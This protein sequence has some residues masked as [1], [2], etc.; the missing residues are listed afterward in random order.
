MILIVDDKPENLFSL[1]T[2]LERHSFKVDT[3]LSG[4]EALK[5]VLRQT[6]SLIILDVQ[7]PDMDGFEVAEAL[8]GSSRSKQ[9]PI[10]FLSAVNTDKKF[11]TKGFDS[12][13]V[14]YI[15]K[16]VDPDILI[17][18]VRTFYRLYEQS[19]ALNDA[20]QQLKAAHTELHLTLNSIP[21]I[22][23]T[24]TPDGQLDFVNQ[25]W[26]QYST[27]PISFPDTPEN[28]PSLEE[29]WQAALTKGN[30]YEQ[31]V[32]IRKLTNQAY[33]FHL[34]RV[35]PVKENNTL[36]KWTGV[37]VDIHDQHEINELLE[38]KIKERT[39]EL[40]E[41]NKS[42]EESNADLQ[43][44]ASIASH[45]LKEPLRKIHLFGSLMKEQLADKDK[46]EKY[47]SKILY[48]SDRMNRLVNDVLSFS[49]LSEID[50]FVHTDLNQIAQEVLVDLELM[51]QE[52][53]AQIHLDP[54][55]HIEAIPG[56]IRQVFQNM[57]S[58]AL[59]FA[60]E[61]QTPVLH[62]HCQQVSTLQADSPE[63]NNGAFYRLVFSDNGIGF[64]EK[65]TQ[66]IFSLFQRLNAQSQYEGTGIGLSI[67]KKI[68]EKHHGLITAHSQPGEGANFI[69][70]LPA[71]Q[72]Q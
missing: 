60:K 59:K 36:I 62:I 55:P 47:L 71:T 29:I 2:I 51:I 63:S 72:Q 23:F 3:A 27:S 37:F 26:Y 13:A 28:E 39:K 57:I 41:A 46:I 11:I 15:T 44:F 52:K 5:K 42:L 65:Y 34:F 68:V 4:E 17:L 56:L 6:Y 25:F 21:Q 30:F 45:D 58:N 70:V 69:V 7:M 8:V 9:T 22:A 1:K 54:L 12:G 24:A 33:R 64:E 38:E 19:A 35:T 61:D 16:P 18:R 31:K 50:R 53:E 20:H 43:Q 10:L 67:A 40:V 49:R 14:D 48:A 66:R 32:R